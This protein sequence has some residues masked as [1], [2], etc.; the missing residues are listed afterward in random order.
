MSDYKIVTK[1][2]KGQEVEVKIY[3]PT[4]RSETFIT[5]NL[6]GKKSLVERKK[7]FNNPINRC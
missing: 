2:I 4:A 5:A 1:K 6:L 3:D 7:I